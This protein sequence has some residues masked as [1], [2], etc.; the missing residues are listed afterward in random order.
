MP[1]WRGDTPGGEEKNN[2]CTC[3]KMSTFSHCCRN[4]VCTRTQKRQNTKIILDR[5]SSGAAVCVC[6]FLLPCGQIICKSIKIT[7]SDQK[8]EALKKKRQKKKRNL[9]LLICKKQLQTFPQQQ[10]NIIFFSLSNKTGLTSTIHFS[11]SQVSFAFFLFTYSSPEHLSSAS[12]AAPAPAS[13]AA[14]TATTTVE[15]ATLINWHFILTPFPPS[16]V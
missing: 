1:L 9:P 14:A 16:S 12:A 13:H 10:G 6:S 15:S 11:G 2:T 4:D 3:S 7:A 5:R 8:K